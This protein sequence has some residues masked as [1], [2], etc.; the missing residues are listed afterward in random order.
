MKLALAGP[1]PETV[2][3]FWK[4]VWQQRSH[5]I[6]MLTQTTEKCKVSDLFLLSF[7]TSCLQSDSKSA[8]LA[9][10]SEN[11]TPTTAKTFVV[12]TCIAFFLLL[13]N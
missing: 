4:M 12:Y 8:I 10:A 13:R 7:E 1:K 11:A 9:I 6:V 3:D 2:N 5:V